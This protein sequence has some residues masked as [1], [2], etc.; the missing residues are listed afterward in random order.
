M[1][2]T[3]L[4]EKVRLKAHLK[5]TKYL[6]NYFDTVLKDIPIPF[7][8]TD[9]RGFILKVNPFFERL[10]GHTQHQVV[11]MLASSLFNLPA[12]W[13]EKEDTFTFDRVKFGYSAITNSLK[14]EGKIIGFVVVLIEKKE[15]SFQSNW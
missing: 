15:L 7:F 13:I 11:G 2:E 1:I 12:N 14:E 9:V 4:E 3:E 8:T 6:A 5:R 10:T